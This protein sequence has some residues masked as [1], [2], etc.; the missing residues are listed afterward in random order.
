MKQKKL[1]PLACLLFI[2]GIIWLMTLFSNM[3]WYVAHIRSEFIM[4]LIII[5]ALLM[6][7]GGAIIILSFFDEEDK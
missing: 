2:T 3:D 5:I 1:F 7:F 6:T 4:A